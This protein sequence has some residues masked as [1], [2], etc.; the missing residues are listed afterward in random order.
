LHCF[1]VIADFGQILAF[2]NTLVIS[3]LRTT[4]FGIKKRKASLCRVVQNATL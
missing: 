1:Q 4:K 2:F 3:E